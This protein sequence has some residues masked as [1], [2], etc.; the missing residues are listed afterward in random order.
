M[1]LIRAISPDLRSLSPGYLV[2]AFSRMPLSVSQADMALEKEL[3]QSPLA[4]QTGL[5]RSWPHP[6]RLSPGVHKENAG[7]TY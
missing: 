2:V 6:M 5:F 7:W 4:V 3:D 1:V